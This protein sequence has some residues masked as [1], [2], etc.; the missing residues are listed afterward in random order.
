MG[1]NTRLPQKKTLLYIG[2]SSGGSEVK[3][4]KK[5]KLPNEDKVHF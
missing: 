4:E 2:V 3:E 1:I 5:E